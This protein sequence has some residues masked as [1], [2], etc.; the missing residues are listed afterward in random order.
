M[1]MSAYKYRWQWNGSSAFEE[2]LYWCRRTFGYA[3]WTNRDINFYFVHEED[4]LM[5]LLK[6]A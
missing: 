2:I 5:F 4:Y 6:W 1:G 3:G